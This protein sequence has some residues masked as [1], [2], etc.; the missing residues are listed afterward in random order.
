[1]SDVRKIH[2]FNIGCGNM[3]EML[4]DDTRG[5]Q[6][7]KLLTK[8]PNGMLINLMYYPIQVL[9]PGKRLGIWTQGCTIRCDHCISTHN[10]EF[11]V[12]KFIS[13]EKV[14]DYINKNGGAKNIEGVT[15]SGGEPFDQHK[16]LDRMLD[17]L[18]TLGFRDILVY[19]GYT[20]EYL[21]D[22]Y[23]HIL[24]KFSVLIDGPFVFG[25]ESDYIWKGS[26]N[27][28]M[29]ILS[30]DEEIL[31]KYLEYQK[32]NKNKELQIVTGKGL[33]YFI[34]IPYQKDAIKFSEI[35]EVKDNE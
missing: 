3:T 18:N 2:V 20:Y 34:G 9:G 27:Q 21:K 24:E 1:M 19:S 23:G 30:K 32:L 13:W 10:W 15:I 33:T 14:V 7:Q 16:E 22:N 12:S 25:K 5:T 11:D 17:I 26:E 6:F 4:N 31:K 28:N 29:Y 8:K 35:S